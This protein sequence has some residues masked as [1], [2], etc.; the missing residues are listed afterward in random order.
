M[1]VKVLDISF[2]FTDD[3][4]ELPLDEQNEIISEVY[5]WYIRVDSED[6]IAD[7]ISDNTGWLVNSL[8]YEIIKQ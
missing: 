3:E 2:D 7:V 1:V 5:K 8:N 4:G 6:E